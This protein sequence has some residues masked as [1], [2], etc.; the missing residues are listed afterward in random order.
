MDAVTRRRVLVA[1]ATIAMA[2][3]TTRARG[4]ANTLGSARLTGTVL[5]TAQLPLPGA[6]VELLGFGQTRTN[7]TGLFRFA[8]VPAGS[9]I[10]HV[11]KIGLE[12]VIRV[13]DLAAGDSVDLDVTLG[14]AAYQLATVVVYRDSSYIMPDATGFDRRRRNGMGHYIS[15]DEIAQRHVSETSELLRTLPGIS[16]NGRGMVTTLRGMNTFIG[17]SCDSVGATVLI[18]GV[19]IAGEQIWGF[20]GFHGE[21]GLNINTIPPAIIRG[22]EVYSGPATT[23]AELVT[24]RSSVCGT[25]AIWTR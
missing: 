11:A 18:D 15:A 10:L 22:I 8:G 24:S 3:V 6:V 9:V 20:R 5:D 16:I 17:T 12:P 14:P 21:T 4:Q 23:P 25:V 2:T 13:I 7:S 1:C 19:E